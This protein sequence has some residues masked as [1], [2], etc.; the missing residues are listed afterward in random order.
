MVVAAA[1][2]V[3]G[4]TSDPA[5]PP[6]PDA[7]ITAFD[8]AWEQLDLAAL[9]A[10]TDAP[11]EAEQLIDEV[12]QSTGAE[13]V[14]VTTDPAVVTGDTATTTAHVQWAL[15]DGAAWTYDVPWQWDRSSGDWK[16]DW[17]PAAV[18]P[19]LGPR[20]RVVVQ[21]TAAEPGT[22]LDRTGQR[23]T[24]PVTVTSV[25]LFPD[26]VP[27]L[28]ATAQQLAGLLAPIDSSITAE[29]IQAG[30]ARAQAEAAQDT[31][32]ATG[33]ATATTGSTPATSGSTPPADPVAYTV[34][35]LRDA[36]FR[37]I[38]AQLDAL[39]GLAFPSQVRNLPPSRTFAR[40]LL[41]EVTQVTDPMMAGTPGVRVVSTDTTG[42]VV[43]VLGDTP[44][45]D[46]AQV[47]LGL[48]IDLQLAAE[49]VLAPVPEPAVFMVMQPSTGEIVVSAQNA[50]ADAQGALA[51]TGRFPP[52]SIFK[53][54]TASAALD[55]GRITPTST[56][57]CPGTTV[58]DGR[59]IDNN[60]TF[61]L[62]AVPVT[63]AFA[64]S[65]NTT[66]ADL[67]SAM[68][69]DTLTAAAQHYGV[70]LDFVVPGIT[71]LTGSVPPSDSPVQRAE[72]GFGQGQVLMTPFSAVLM[73]ATAATGTMPTP[74][75]I[76]GTTTTVDRPA[77]A[78][79]PAVTE[80]VRSF[81]AAVASLDGTAAVLLP[82]GDVHAKTG[83]AEYQ[84]ADGTIRAHA[85][86]VAYRH[87]LAVVAFIED[88]QLSGRTNQLIA[89]FLASIPLD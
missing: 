56:V 34:V 26:Q 13:S 64:R 3:T 29:T 37:P 36:D 40:T 86:T 17:S 83:T 46:G 88:G 48:D 78:Q 45:V 6:G 52:G 32:T 14:T 42:S 54:V 15:P 72:N 22:L 89:D 30:V 25:V 9:A 4:C 55:D 73:A 60:Q 28:P 84:A 82:F 51:L 31:A 79:E 75:V 16:L 18:H 76:R 23:I 58:I 33:E 87:D 49:A 39:P 81:M 1:V 85:W 70:G 10:A 69:T 67:A 71:T 5:P 24:G 80:A 11:G 66:F 21:T 57:D 61:A 19:Q 20:Q 65:C 77:P 62:G 59:A 27:D 41:A 74:T 35:N 8:Q 12:V 38:A 2:V 47:T 50:A 7:T 43:E 63:E 68:D 53:I 44:A